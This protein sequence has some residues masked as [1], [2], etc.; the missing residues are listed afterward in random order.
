MLPEP[1]AAI[2]PPS[3]PTAIA[4][5]KPKAEKGPPR[6]RG[7]RSKEDLIMRDEKLTANEKMDALLKLQ[8][9]NEQKP[10]AAPDAPKQEDARKS[11]LTLK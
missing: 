11:C 2:V 1:A 7:R 3:I 8:P 9:K 5:E 10:Q 4:A 6:K